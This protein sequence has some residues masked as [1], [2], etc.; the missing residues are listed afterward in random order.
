MNSKQIAIKYF[1]PK[2]CDP[3]MIFNDINIFKSIL[4]WAKDSAKEFVETQTSKMFLT[5]YVDDVA[6]I[7]DEYLINRAAKM[8][9]K[10][11]KSQNKLFS[12]LCSSEKIVAWIIDRWINTFINLT[13]NSK[14]RDYIDISKIKI[15][16]D[17][18]MD[19]F[20][21]DIEEEIEFEKLK[22]LPK[23]SIKKALKKVWEDSKYDLDF[24]YLDFEELC[25]EFEFDAN[26]VVG[27]QTFEEPKFF[28]HQ[29]NN[30]HYQLELLF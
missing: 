8:Y 5:S 19:F 29:V 3:R 23:E 4:P 30:K 18:N 9:E 1:A 11:I 17:S 28:K 27:S 13:S 25:C 21:S 24:D 2:I 22:K 20:S 16:F 26:E 12:N 10:A 15:A 6:P 14:Y 7:V